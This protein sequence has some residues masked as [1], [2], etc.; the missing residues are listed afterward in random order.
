MTRWSSRSRSCPPPRDPRGWTALAVA[1]VEQLVG[2]LERGAT[3]TRRAPR[4]RCTPGLRSPEM[5]TMADDGQP[6]SIW[7]KE[8]SFRRKPGEAVAEPSRGSR[9]IEPRGGRRRSPRSRR[10]GGGSSRR[11]ARGPAA[12]PS[13]RLQPLSNDWLTKPLEEVSD[14]PSEPVSPVAL[15]PVPL[16]EPEPGSMCRRSLPGGQPSPPGRSTRRRASS[17][18]RRPTRSPSPRGPA[19]KSPSTRR[20]SRSSAA[21]KP[22]SPDAEARAKQKRFRRAPKE[23]DAG[24]GSP[25]EAEDAPDAGTPGVAV[26]PL[27]SRGSAGK[28]L[29]GLKIGGSQIAPARIRNTGRQSSSRR[30]AFRSSMGSSSTA[31]CAIRGSRGGP[32]GVLAA[33]SCRSAASGSGSPTTGSASAPSR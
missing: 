7:K 8:I 33:H 1:S 22:R 28:Q 6:T 21:R 15:E 27:L 9:L 26:T 4:P 31:S 23:W 17:R 32:E 5:L 30:R 18:D 2:L 29:V 13:L 10:F 3:R 16:P 20:S 19:S 24:E 14:P 25:E 11:W 12:S